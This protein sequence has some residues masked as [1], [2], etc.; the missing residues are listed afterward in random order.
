MNLKTIQIDAYLGDVKGR[1]PDPSAGEVKS[2]VFAPDPALGVIIIFRKSAL[3]I[4]WEGGST[5]VSGR[6]GV[7]NSWSPEKQ[8]ADAELI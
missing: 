4:R 6:A 3:V 5:K 2:E 8:R 1:C 7:A